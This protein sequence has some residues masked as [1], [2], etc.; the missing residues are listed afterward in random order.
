METFA[1][2][3]AVCGYH[4]YQDV[5]KPSIGEKCNKT[6]GHLPCEFSRI[7][8]YFLAC[9][10]EIKQNANE[11]LE[12][13]IC[14]QNSGLEPEDANKRPLWEPPL[15]TTESSDQQQVSICLIF[16]Y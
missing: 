12:R 3:S 6:V 14:E 16:S 4:V 7:A 8:W 9:S 5:W 11:T 1:F 15:L 2:E 10:G 13:T